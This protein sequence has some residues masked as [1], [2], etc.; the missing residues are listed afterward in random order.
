MHVSPQSRKTIRR[1]ARRRCFRTGRR[2]EPSPAVT[3]LRTARRTEVRTARAAVLAST[4]PQ[5]PGVAEEEPRALRVGREQRRQPVR[6]ARRERDRQRRLVCLDGLA[7]LVPDVADPVDTRP[8]DVADRLYVAPRA[9]RA[10]PL[11]RLHAPSM[12]SSAPTNRP[13][14][15]LNEWLGNRASDPEEG[16]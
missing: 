6:P 16:C 2:A 10:G 15:R 12:A 13:V 11:D 4:T 5:R 3:A 8:D 9:V 14:R 7:L 1:R